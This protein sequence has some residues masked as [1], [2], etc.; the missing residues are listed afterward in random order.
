MSERFKGHKFNY[1]FDYMNNR[2]FNCGPEAVIGDVTLHPYIWCFQAWLVAYMRTEWTITKNVWGL[3]ALY[4]V[5]NKTTSYVNTL[6]SLIR[7]RIFNVVKCV[8]NAISVL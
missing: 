2:T 8:S 5:D 1:N 3:I 4:L 6:V 7:Q